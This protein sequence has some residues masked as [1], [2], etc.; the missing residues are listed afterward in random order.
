M[1]SIPSASEPVLLLAEQR[2]CLQNISWQLFEN[3]LTE[4]GTNG[5]NRLAYYQ[6]VLEFMTP[7]PEHERP[8]RRIDTL[9][10]ELAT[11]LNL[12]LDLL[13]S[14]TIKRP[15]LRAGKEPDACYYIQNEYLIRNKSQLDFTQD[16]PPDLAVEV[17]ITHS[18]IDRLALYA[19]LGVPELW[20]YDGKILTFYY[21][22]NGNYQIVDRSVSFPILS[23]VKVVEFLNDCRSLG[24][25]AAVRS[26][27]Q[28][29][30]TQ[31]SNLTDENP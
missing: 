2:I 16:P 15:D 23:A 24:V 22:E 19:T 1:V 13:G 6:G 26:F 27:R 21:L 25:S 4:I 9:V 7:L 3:L 20:Y 28:W 11:A 8:I 30:T 12:P 17:D 10:V 5:T 31:I 18:S 14:V 29:I